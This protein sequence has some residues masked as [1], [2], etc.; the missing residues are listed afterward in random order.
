MDDNE[1]NRELALGMLEMYG[2]EVDCAEDGVHA[3]QCLDATAYDLVLMDCHMPEMDGFEATRA[4]RARERQ[5][6]RPRVIII[7][8]T[9][10]A[11]QGD[12]ETCLAAG[13]DDYV[14]KPFTRAMLDAALGRWLARDG[15]DPASRAPCASTRN[16]GCLA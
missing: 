9:A 4:W 5:E 12:R 8:L 16:D 2:V 10:A 7:A 1:I 13:M 3:L 11:M 6:G 15:A 14:A